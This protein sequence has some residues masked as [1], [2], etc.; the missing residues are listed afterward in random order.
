MREMMR[1]RGINPEEIYAMMQKDR[2]NPKKIREGMKE[3]GIGVGNYFPPVHLQPF[4]A[5]QFG[6]QQ[7]DFPITEAASKS[8]IALPFYNNLSKDH[9]ATVCRT[10]KEVLDLNLPSR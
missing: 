2:L 1:E 6:C 4:I 9:V 10:L 8:T 5:K 7:G 3:K